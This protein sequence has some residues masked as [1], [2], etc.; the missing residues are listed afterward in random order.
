MSYSLINKRLLALANCYGIGHC[1]YSKIIFTVVWAFHFTLGVITPKHHQLFFYN[2]IA[3][4]MFYS[5]SI[6][7]ASHAGHF[8]LLK[9]YM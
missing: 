7:V 2:S 6:N 3:S 1:C 5:L 4:I 9:V 8:N